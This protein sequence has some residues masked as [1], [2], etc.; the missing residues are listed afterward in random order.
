MAHLYI[1]WVVGQRQISTAGDVDVLQPSFQIPESDAVAEGPR[2]K[3]EPGHMGPRHILAAIYRKSQSSICRER[4]LKIAEAIE[5]VHRFG[6][7]VIRL[8]HQVV[9]MER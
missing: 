9:L 6:Q 7:L 4:V 3:V 1:Q 5:R 8:R 2:I